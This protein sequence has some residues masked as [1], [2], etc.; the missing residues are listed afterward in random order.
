MAGNFKSVWEGWQLYRQGMMVV[1]HPPLCSPPS[2]IGILSHSVSA[3]EVI[4]QQIWL[5]ATGG[6]VDES[7]CKGD[8]R[9]LLVC[10]SGDG[11]LTI[12]MATQIAVQGPGCCQR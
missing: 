4:T 1:G 10:S 9:C 6:I 3:Y 2:A 5:I 7:I 12:H 8:L 11:Q